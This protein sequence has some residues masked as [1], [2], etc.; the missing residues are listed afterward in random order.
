MVGIQSPCIK[1]CVFDQMAGLCIGCGRTL[2][3][4]GQ[5]LSLTEVERSRVMG[6]LPQRLAALKTD[7]MHKAEPA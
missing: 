3:E 7:C 2:N 4:I 6:E 1:I 5:W